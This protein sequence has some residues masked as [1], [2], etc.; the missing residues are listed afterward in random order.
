[1]AVLLVPGIPTTAKT[2]IFGFVGNGA[3]FFT[4]SLT[5]SVADIRNCFL[6]NGWNLKCV[7]IVYAL[8]VVEFPVSGDNG[9]CTEYP[10]PHDDVGG[11]HVVHVEADQC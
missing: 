1:M 10:P 2:R 3:A 11:G 9:V 6:K 5:W 7:S 8:V 4:F